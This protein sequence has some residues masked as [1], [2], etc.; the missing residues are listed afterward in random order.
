MNQDA[1]QSIVIALRS[2]SSCKQHVVKWINNQHH[3]QHHHHQQNTVYIL[4]TPSAAGFSGNSAVS[5]QR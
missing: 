2:V 5:L 4:A 1:F 3:Q